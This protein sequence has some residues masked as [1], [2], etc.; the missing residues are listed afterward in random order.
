M[1]YK[2]YGITFQGVKAFL[3]G[4]SNCKKKLIKIK[5]YGENGDKQTFFVIPSTHASLILEAVAGEIRLKF[6]VK[7]S[8][9]RA[10]PIAS[11]IAKNIDEAKN[12]GGS[13]TK[14]L[15][16]FNQSYLKW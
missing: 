7:P 1:F 16:K 14:K 4:T 5:S 2:I 13:P 8:S 10:A 12:N 3:A 6:G 11:F 15:Q 9:F